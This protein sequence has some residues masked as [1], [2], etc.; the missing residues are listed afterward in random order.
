MRPTVVAVG[1]LLEKEFNDGNY[2]PPGPKEINAL[3]NELSL[4]DNISYYI[5]LNDEGL[6]STHIEDDYK[7][8]ISLKE[9]IDHFNI[10][11]KWR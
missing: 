2:V 5:S 4:F 9:K 10:Y 8:F 7:E 6:S 11:Q 3:C 1:T